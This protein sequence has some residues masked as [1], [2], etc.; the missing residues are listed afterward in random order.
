[1]KRI[2]ILLA[3]AVA[4]ALFMGC[5][6]STST[7]KQSDDS[8][9]GPPGEIIGHGSGRLNCKT[10]PFSGPGPD[11]WRHSSFF[12]GPFG[13]TRNF[14]I[15][16]REDDG[17]M[18]AKTPV[19]VEGHRSVVLSVPRGE[20]DRVGIELVDGRRPF[21]AITLTPC[22]GKKRTAWATGLVFRDRR[23]VHLEVRIGSRAG[24]IEV[25]RPR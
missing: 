24:T 25:G 23:P 7:A 12:F 17:L 2:W 11:D 6:S 10:Y 3:L 18:R 15:G 8:A 4:T 16:S 5:G 22:A 9:P 1:M 19:I 14:A 13:L 20:R 21:S